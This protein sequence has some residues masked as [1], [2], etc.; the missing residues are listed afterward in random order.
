MQQPEKPVSRLELKPRLLGNEVVLVGTTAQ[1]TIVRV[2]RDR[3]GENVTWHLVELPAA[4]TKP[5][6]RR[7]PANPRKTPPRHK[8]GRPGGTA[9]V[10]ALA[11]PPTLPSHHARGGR[12]KIG[13]KRR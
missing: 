1:G 2:E 7:L 3:T 8:R 4:E 11:R 13:P 5:G 10:S 6:E 12:R 9:P